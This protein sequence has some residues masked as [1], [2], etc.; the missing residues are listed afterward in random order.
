[1]ATVAATVAICRGEARTSRWP[2]ALWAVAGTSW[3]AGIVL[4]AAGSW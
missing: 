3:S 2:M 1:L 4:V